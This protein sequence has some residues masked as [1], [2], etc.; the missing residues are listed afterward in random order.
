RHAQVYHG[1]DDRGQLV[2]TPR[3]A[4]RTGSADA[5]LVLG[6]ATDVTPR[7]ERPLPRQMAR[8]K[9]VGEA[10]AKGPL[11]ELY[12]GRKARSAAKVVPALLRP[13]ILRHSHQARG[14]RPRRAGA[15]TARCWM[16]RRADRR[17]GLRH[18]ALQS[19]RPS[20]R[21]LRHRAA[22]DVRARRNPGR[23]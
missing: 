2:L 22:F 19:F 5:S 18:R 12:A 4:P 15:V 11:A 7:P 14:P 16:A 1:G 21:Y 13:M 8:I 9:M 20:R 3:H 6:R 17:N 23:R 10:E